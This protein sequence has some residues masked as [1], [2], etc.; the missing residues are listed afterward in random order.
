MVL[1][2]NDEIMGDFKMGNT[3]KYNNIIKRKFTEK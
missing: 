3:E 1:G 2:I